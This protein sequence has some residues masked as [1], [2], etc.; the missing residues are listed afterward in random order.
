MKELCKLWGFRGLLAI[1]LLSLA[2]LSGCSRGPTEE[3]LSLEEEAALIERVSQRWHAMEAKDFEAVYEY[4]T[5]NYRSIFPKHMFLNN[6]GYDVNWELTEV[7]VVNYDARVAVASVVVRVMSEPT[8]LT[9]EASIAIGALPAVVREKWILIDG[10]WWN[11]A[12]I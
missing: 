10:E 4:M 6:L 11:S 12:K 5:P 7:E 2:L 3:T 1:A 9:S 8:K